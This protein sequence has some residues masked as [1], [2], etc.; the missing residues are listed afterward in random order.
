MTND[1]LLSSHGAG[2]IHP[3]A[4][5]PDDVD[6]NKL[7]MQLYGYPRYARIAYNRTS[8]INTFSNHSCMKDC[9]IWPHFNGHNFVNFLRPETMLMTNDH[10]C[11]AGSSDVAKGNNL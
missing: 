1:N 10:R 7:D 8:E 5:G 9:W 4:I 2:N 11:L 6:P 3:S